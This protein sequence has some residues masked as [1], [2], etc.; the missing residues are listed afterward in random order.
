MSDI[1]EFN[2]TERVRIIYKPKPAYR[3]EWSSNITG[4]TFQAYKSL[5][6]REGVSMSKDICSYIK[7]RVKKAQKGVE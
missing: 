7:S 2:G 5:C 1:T 6:L 4:E 3:L